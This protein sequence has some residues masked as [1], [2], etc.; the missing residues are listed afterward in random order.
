MRRL[1]PAEH[2]RP[3]LGVNPLVFGDGL[4]GGRGSAR[5]C[6]AS[7]TYLSR[8]ARRV[9][10]GDQAPPSAYRGPDL[11]VL[12]RRRALG[13]PSLSTTGWRVCFRSERQVILSVLLPP[14][15]VLTSR[16]L[17]STVG[18][19][20]RHFDDPFLLDTGRLSCAEPQP[21]TA[22]LGRTHCWPPRALPSIAPAVSTTMS[23]FAKSQS[24]RSVKLDCK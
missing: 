4:G 3:D 19:C 12:Y 6:V 14:C 5:R 9:A 7:M 22:S 13:H 20:P 10:L 16:V 2:G 17:L 18:V 8:W 15:V 11:A 21:D 1:Q 24:R 23:S